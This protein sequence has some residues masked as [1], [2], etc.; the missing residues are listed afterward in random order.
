MAIKSFIKQFDIRAAI[1]FIAAHFVSVGI[2]ELLVVNDGFII[3]KGGFIMHMLQAAVFL[4]IL[5]LKIKFEL[6]VAAAVTS[7]FYLLMAINWF[8]LSRWGEVGIQ[9]YFHSVFPSI[10]MTIN[11]IVI[12]LLGKD[13]V[14]PILNKF[15]KRLGFRS[16][17]QLLFR[18]TRSHTVYNISLPLRKEDLKNEEGCK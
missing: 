17:L 12:F 3:P 7:V 5:L 18:S 16:H 14:I 4:S 8:C 13:D 11:L 2:Y 15:F 1:I 10:I 6:A 9:A